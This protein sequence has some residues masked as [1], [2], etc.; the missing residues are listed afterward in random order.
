MEIE[1]QNLVKDLLGKND[2]QLEIKLSALARVVVDILTKRKRRPQ[3]LQENRQCT[4]RWSV[5]S[6]SER[7]KGTCIRLIVRLG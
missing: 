5:D 4:K 2:L 6:T 1:N 3:G 7:Q